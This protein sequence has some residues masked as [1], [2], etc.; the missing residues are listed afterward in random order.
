MQYLIGVGVAD[1]ADQPRIGERSLEGSVFCCKCRTKAGDIAG[2]DINSSRINRFQFLLSSNDMQRCS[3]L[4][5]SFRKHQRTIGK[6]EG[7]QIVSAMKL[8]FSR[9]PMQSSGDH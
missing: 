3:T 5:T 6:V 9:S 1:S 7:C 8:S 4:C 2:E